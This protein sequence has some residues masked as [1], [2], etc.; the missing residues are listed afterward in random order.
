MGNLADLGNTGLTALA[1]GGQTGAT[2][3]IEGINIVTVCAT[4][5]DSV[6]LPIARAG[7]MIVRVI[8]L[9]AQP[10]QVF[11]NSATAD[12]IS[13]ALNTIASATGYP[14]GVGEI[15]DYTCQTGASPI[16][17]SSTPT[18]YSAG[19]WL[20]TVIQAGKEAMLNLSAAAPAVNPHVSAN[21]NF[22]RAGVVAAT[23][24]APTATTDDGVLISFTNTTTDQDTVTFTGNTLDSGAAG[25][26]TATFPA[27][28]G[29]SIT[30]R[31]RNAR[32][33]LVSNNLVVIT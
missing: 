24:A 9:G 12:T 14:Q 28:A 21:Y 4:A 25:V 33:Q 8:N 5:Q 22:T 1:G 20:A 10:C 2:A 16:A 29:G 23:I 26:L 18:K 32:W 19:N 7:G 31:A 27:H 30:V 11:G 13:G 17:P 15:V 3:L 6:M